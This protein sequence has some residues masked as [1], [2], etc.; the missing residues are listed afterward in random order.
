[1]RVIK[2]ENS[3]SLSDTNRLSHQRE[4]AQNRG[5]MTM[6]YISEGIL[7]KDCFDG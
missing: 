7:S 5:N 3:A 2:Q 6:N 1:M 4:I